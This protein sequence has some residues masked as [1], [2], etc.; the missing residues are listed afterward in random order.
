M[1]PLTRCHGNPLL[2]EWVNVGGI[3]GSSI[4]YQ[5]HPHSAGQGLVPDS[6]GVPF[7]CAGALVSYSS[8]SPP[9]H[10]LSR[11]GEAAARQALENME[12]GLAETRAART[13]M[14]GD[15]QGHRGRET[16]STESWAR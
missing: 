4:H 14:G 10:L 12:R 15:G 2:S 1:P 11:G 13:R 9:R 5:H 8:Q 6:P 16:N 3:V 7:R